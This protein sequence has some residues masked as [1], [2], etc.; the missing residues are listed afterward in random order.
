MFKKIISTIFGLGKKEEEVDTLLYE[1]EETAIDEPD[2][3]L[4]VAPRREP[5]PD[6]ILVPKEDMS[7]ALD[8]QKQSAN[9]QNRFGYLVLSFE[10]KKKEILTQI[11]SIKIDIDIEK[12]NIKNKFLP[13]EEKENYFL[14]VNDAGEFFLNKKQDQE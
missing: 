14:A 3:P 1:P 13:A 8:L 7:S 11:E 9:L 5:L 12:D 4:E 2:P 10:T 6:K